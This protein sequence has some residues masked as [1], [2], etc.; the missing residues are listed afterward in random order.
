M[1]KSPPHNM[2]SIAH[3]CNTDDIKMATTVFGNWS[4]G[5]GAG[6]LTIIEGTGAGHLPIK[7]PAG[8][9]I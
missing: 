2:S 6:H 5:L 7:L 8:P 9:G 1:T 3:A 4:D